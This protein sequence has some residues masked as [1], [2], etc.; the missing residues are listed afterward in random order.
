M[1]SADGRRRGCVAFALA[2]AAAVAQAEPPAPPRPPVAPPLEPW[3]EIRALP[4]SP[5]VAQ[6][7]R[8]MRVEQADTL[9]PERRPVD[10]AA[11]S[12]GD[13]V[14]HDAGRDGGQRRWTFEADAAGVPRR[15]YALSNAAGPRYGMLAEVACDDTAAE[16]T[17]LRER[18]RSMRAPP[19]FRDGWGDPAREAL[20]DMRYASWLELLSTEPC[21][22][23]PINR[24]QPRYP[25]IALR[26]GA[27]GR[28]VVL[29]AFNRCGEF[30]DVG[31]RRS[32]GNRDLD[33][34]AV[35]TLRQWHVGR[36]TVGGEA[37]QALVP[38]DFS[39]GTDEPAPASA[40][41]LLVPS[42]P[43]SPPAP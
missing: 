5:T 33:R 32:T 19:P 11:W 36:E 29:V 17:R 7:Y 18:L 37:G 14:F 26:A 27:E 39:L 25:P 31:I 42:P 12:E 35:A 13:A 8:E 20:A 30:R 23:Q 2:A 41:P 15:A 4:A 28:A 1:P 22:D 40:D 6:R 24:P 43:P 38:V 9:P 3:L 34:A 21:T 10:P 16:C